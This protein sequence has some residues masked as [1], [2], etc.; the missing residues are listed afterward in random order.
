[1]NAELYSSS[2]RPFRNDGRIRGPIAKMNVAKN[3]TVTA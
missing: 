1:M 3:P 2:S